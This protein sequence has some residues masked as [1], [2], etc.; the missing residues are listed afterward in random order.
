MTLRRGEEGEDWH[1]G[2][3]AISKERHVGE[4]AWEKLYHKFV[5]MN[6]QS[7]FFIRAGIAGPKPC[8]KRDMQRRGDAYHDQ[9]SEQAIVSRDAV[10]HASAGETLAQ[11]NDGSGRSFA[12]SGGVGQR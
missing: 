4:A 7:T 5:E 6:R 8:G 10:Q 11:T 2:C 1:A 12:K 9:T 3:Q